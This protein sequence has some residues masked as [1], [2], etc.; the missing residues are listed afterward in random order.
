MDAK[1]LLES[2]RPRVGIAL[3]LSGLSVVA[4]IRGAGAATPAPG[5]N[6]DISTQE[7]IITGTSIKRANAETA[8]PVQVLSHEDIART[9][10]TSVEEL[11]H[12]IS[13]A[14]SFGSNVAEQEVGQ[15]TG[16]I[17]TISLRGLRSSRTLV[18][19]NGRRSPVYG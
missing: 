12:G 17:S 16:S 5:G 18:L 8:L 19:I 1:R 7:V 11:F 14:A 9:G 13:S 6:D 3:F 15:T 10:A 2:A 4:Y